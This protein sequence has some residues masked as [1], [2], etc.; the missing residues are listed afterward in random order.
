MDERISVDL[1]GEGGFE[2]T[3][4]RL[5][6]MRLRA[7]SDAAEGGWVLQTE[8]GLHCEGKWGRSEERGSWARIA[9]CRHQPSWLLAQRE[10]KLTEG[11]G[12]TIRTWIGW[13]KCW[14]KSLRCRDICSSAKQW[15][16]EG[17]GFW[18]EKLSE[19]MRPRNRWFKTGETSALLRAS[20]R[21][22]RHRR[23]SGVS[24]QVGG[25]VAKGP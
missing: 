9:G 18:E 17:E 13:G 20:S 24:V 16:A 7:S 2:E 1:P 22:S 5:F 21:D 3:W 15:A 4:E 12:S 11:H 10:R 6:T 8:L 23:A 25:S 19:P 14:R